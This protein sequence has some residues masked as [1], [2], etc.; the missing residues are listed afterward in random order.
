MNS[1][2]ARLLPSLALGAFLVVGCSD[3]GASNSAS[4]PVPAM[5]AAAQPAAAQPQPAPAVIDRKAEAA[6]KAASDEAVAKAKAAAD[7]AAAQAKAAADKA[8]A[9]A[10][11]KAEPGHE[12]HG[13][14]GLPHPGTEPVVENPNSKAKLQFEVGSD[15]KNFGKVL[16]GDVLNHVFE[17]VSIGEEDLIIRQAKPTCG[18]TV[19]DVKV[20]DDKG[21]FV[22]YEYGKPIPKGRKVQFNAQLHTQNKRQQAS[23]KV[24]ISTNEARGQA[25][26][27]LEAYVEP[28]FNLTPMSI[29]FSSLGTRDTATDKI[30]VTTARGDRIKL[31]PV[32]EGV[33]NGLKIELKPIDEDA[34]GKASRFE[35]LVTAGPGLSE[36]SIVYSLALRS[37]FEIPGAERLPNGKAPTYEVSTSIMAVVRGSVSLSQSFF[38]F[39]L[40]KP[41]TPKSLTT[42]LT[43]NDP[44]FKLSP[45]LVS[46]TLKGRD[47][48]EWD[49]AQYFQATVR[50]VPNENSVDIELSTTGLPDSLAGSFNGLAVI[51]TGHP[52]KPQFEI[53]I[54]GVCR[55]AA[56]VPGSGVPTAP[57]GQ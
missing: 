2:L 51:K 54:S 35:V 48:A 49:R 27:S 10:K 31:T 13:H 21:E 38:S 3:Q 25:I 47:T 39:G 37:D 33:P 42:R 44:G 14:D 12:G 26:L 46:V 22:R 28:F 41:N 7:L 1:T 43:S 53:G 20:Q 17:A 9:A 6:A 19:A 56:V 57:K 32:L 52:E 40:F 11:P 8:A 16:Q 45:E 30:T 50:P 55:G 23:S 18:C 34:E 36:G 5:P 15:S 24:N 4:Q 29:N